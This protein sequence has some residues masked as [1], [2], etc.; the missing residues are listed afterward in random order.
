MYKPLPSYQDAYKEIEDLLKD[1]MKI[2]SAQKKSSE[3][4]VIIDED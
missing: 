4:E 2:N 3:D 1:S